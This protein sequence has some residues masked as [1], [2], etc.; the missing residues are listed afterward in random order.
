MSAPARLRVL[1]VDDHLVVRRGLVALLGDEPDLEVVAQ[2]A[3]V[4]QALDLYRVHRPDVTLM[5]L[6]MPDGTGVEAIAS[7][8]QIDARARI[9]VLT[10]QAGEEA[11]FQALQA[12]AQGYLTKDA[13]GPEIVAAIRAVHRGER[14]L[15]AGVAATMAQ[16]LKQPALSPR[17]ITVLELIGRG[18]SNKGIAAELKLSTATVQN[19]VAAVLQKLG[20][21]SRAHAVTLALERSIIDIDDLRLG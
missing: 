4:R 12:G 18:F 20:A 19:H 7:I 5:D 9:L 10:I 8:Q 14:C 15:P 11:V 17:E 3:N 13:P 6:K 2:A 21:D 16:R 1:V